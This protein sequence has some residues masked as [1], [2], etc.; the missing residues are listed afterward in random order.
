MAESTVSTYRTPTEVK[1]EITRVK[2]RIACVLSDQLSNPVPHAEAYRRE[3]RPLLE[4]LARLRERHRHAA[5]TILH[6]EQR[7]LYFEGRLRAVNNEVL[8]RRALALAERLN[9]VSVDLESTEGQLAEAAR[10]DIE[11]LVE[12]VRADQLNK[13]HA[14]DFRC[15]VRG[16]SGEV[17]D[18]KSLLRDD[19]ARFKREEAELLSRLAALDRH[20]DSFAESRIFRDQILDDCYEELAELQARLKDAEGRQQVRA[21]EEGLAE[22]GQLLG[23]L[24]ETDGK[25]AQQLVDELAAALREMTGTAVQS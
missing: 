14:R 7:A 4:Q 8:V 3:A 25:T 19:S 11:R 15:F 20:W 17:A 16:F 18:L 10:V 24:A 13:D 1:A 22:L 2:N 6:C 12:R 5:E 21:A 9:D 23:G